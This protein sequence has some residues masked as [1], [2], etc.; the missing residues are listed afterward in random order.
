MG[1]RGG[2]CVSVMLW[3]VA[4]AFAGTTAD[5]HTISSSRLP[6]TTPS[7]VAR[8]HFEKGMQALE[9]L[10]RA[11]AVEDLRT[12]VTADPNF[13]QA[14]ILI[15]HLSH[16]PAEQPDKALAPVSTALS[17]ALIPSSGKRWAM[18]APLNS[19][20]SSSGSGSTR[21]DPSGR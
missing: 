5:S 1:L 17:A 2:A 6:V 10:R 9:Y 21:E 3:S 11:E 19:C 13:A 4:V 7:A 18:R 16:D 14:L 15:S 20:R 8:K 12:A